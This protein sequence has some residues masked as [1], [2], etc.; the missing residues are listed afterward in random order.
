MNSYIL[1]TIVGVACYGLGWLS[2]SIYLD[3]KKEKQDKI[4]DDESENKKQLEQCKND[5][6][7]QETEQRPSEEA[8]DIEPAQEETKIS[9]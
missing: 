8:E 2:Y 3:F 4:I 9:D 5:E 6:S 1:L 7:K